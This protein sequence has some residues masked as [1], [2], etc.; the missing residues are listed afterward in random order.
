[1][2]I[3]NNLLIFFKTH[4]VYEVLNIAPVFLD[5]DPKLEIDLITQEAFYVLPRLAPYVF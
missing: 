4:V 3:L 2:K 5:F 1:M